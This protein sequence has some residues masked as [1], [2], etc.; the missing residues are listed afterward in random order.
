ML[1][2]CPCCKRKISNTAETCP[3]CGCDVQKELRENI[4]FAIWCAKWGGIPFIIFT[5][6]VFVLS[7]T[8]ENNGGI[9]LWIWLIAQIGWVIFLKRDVSENYQ[10]SDDEDNKNQNR[11]NNAN[12]ENLVLNNTR[13]ASSQSRNSV[14]KSKNSVK[15]RQG[16]KIE[17]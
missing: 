7:E 4:E 14:R 16:R 9:C 10:E 17:I 5:F 8:I 3:W 13:S 1:I 11:I 12:L 2:S 15:K 6:S